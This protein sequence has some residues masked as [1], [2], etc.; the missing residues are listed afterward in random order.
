MKAII[1]DDELNARLALR[2]ILEENFSQVEILGE[3][4]DVPG[5]VQMINALKP[6]LVFLDI[7]MPGYSGLELFKFFDQDN[8]PFK[9]IFVTAH[10][11][12]AINAIELSATD[13]ILKPVKVEAL[14]RAIKRSAQ[15]KPEQMSNLVENLTG[16]KL[17]KIALHTGDGIT[18]LPVSEII[19][20]KAAG[21][22]THFNID[23]DRTITITKKISEFL[24]LEKVSD[25][26]RIHRSHIVNLDRI[27]KIIKQEGGSV[28]MDNGDVLSVSA[29]KKQLLMERFSKNRF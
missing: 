16:G 25:F 13:Y 29:D 6:D 27:R 20:L 11:E 12:Y 15:R 1:V 7:S 9:V 3:C 23:N 19:Y 17:K 21:S 24:G 5:A 2:G 10:S 4:K 26:M 8:L 28:E 18:L 22:Y 14:E